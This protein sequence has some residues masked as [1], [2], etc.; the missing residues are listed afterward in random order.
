MNTEHELK[1]KLAWLLC[2]KSLKLKQNGRGAM[3]TAKNV[4]IGLLG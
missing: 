1:S 2:Q 4:F 3:T